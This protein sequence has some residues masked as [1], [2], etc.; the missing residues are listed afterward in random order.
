MKLKVKILK[1]NYQISKIDHDE[2]ISVL[3]ASSS[4]NESWSDTEENLKDFLYQKLNI[5]RVGIDRV[6]RIGKP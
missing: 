3:M 4:E 1:T 5:Q 2:I 6:H